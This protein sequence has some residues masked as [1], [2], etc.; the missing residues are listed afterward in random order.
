MKVLV[1][2]LSFTQHRALPQFETELFSRKER[3]QD[4]S[5]QN[6]NAKAENGKASMLL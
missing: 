4:V 6:K 5:Q 2:D 3:L 1:Y